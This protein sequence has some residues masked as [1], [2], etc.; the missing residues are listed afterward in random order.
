MKELLIS[1]HD[2][3]PFYGRQVQIIL[4]ELKKRKIKKVSIAIVPQVDERYDP[5]GKIVTTSSLITKYPAFV[6]AIKRVERQGAQ[7]LLH[8]LDHRDGRFVNSARFEQRIKTAIKNFTK[9]FGHKPA[10]YIPPLWRTSRRANK[11]LAKYFTHSED[12]FTID[13][14]GKKTWWGFPVCMDSWS[15]NR[16]FTHDVITSVIARWYSI[17]AARTRRDGVL[18]LSL[19]P[20][21][22]DN[23]NLKHNLKL[24]DTLLNHGWKARTYSELI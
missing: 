22:V 17:I 5:F 4:Q 21:E 8:G 24:L 18:R 11:T 20:R 14:F 2:A 12:V 16:L 23:G 7:L 3:S 15:S 9:A 10:G 19:H 6:K 1:I 13:M